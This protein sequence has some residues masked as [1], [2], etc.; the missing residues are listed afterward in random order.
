MA[1]QPKP[2][3]THAPKKE[4]PVQTRFSDWASI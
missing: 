2:A 3:P 1:Q 4:T